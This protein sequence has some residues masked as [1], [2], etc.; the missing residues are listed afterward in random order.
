MAR[1]E[2]PQ[3]VLK[4]LAH[5]AQRLAIALLPPICGLCRRGHDQPTAIC[6][7]CIEALQRNDHACARCAE[8]AHHLNSQGHCYRCQRKS[9]LFVSVTAPFLM[10]GAMQQLIHQWK[11][12]GHT[13]LSPILAALLV[14]QLMQ[15]PRIAADAAKVE[16]LLGSPT[17]DNP[18]TNA[19][20]S[21][22]IGPASP[23]DNASA[24]RFTL[25]PAVTR[26][27]NAPGKAAHSTP[28]FL[29]PIP[30]HS[31]RRWHRG[32]D[33]TWL[34]ANNLTKLCGIPLLRGLKRTRFASAQH[35][36]RRRERAINMRNAFT[37]QCQLSGEHI[38]LVDDVVTTGATA[39]AATQALLAAGA[40][41]VEVWCLA[42]TPGP[43]R[44]VA[45]SL[46]HVKSRHLKP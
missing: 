4:G 37:A 7:H 12:D 28:Q 8:P 10:V 32:F 34:L 1:S 23:S 14:K 40:G 27:G 22:R 38:T 13:V 35:Q 42:R 25:P 44:K 11:F 5:R 15:Q 39:T 46:T 33:Q 20:R 2:K 3:W 9:P 31:R 43:E 41:S 17:G 36:L 18:A 19:S 24:R 26:V 30:S 16:A 45:Y 21:A 6:W 29:V